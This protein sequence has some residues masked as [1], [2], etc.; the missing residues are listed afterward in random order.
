MKNGL[1]RSPWAPGTGHVNMTVGVNSTVS[2]AATDILDGVALEYAFA[3][4]ALPMGVILNA[5]GTIS[6]MPA[7]VGDY[8]FSVYAYVAG[9]PWAGLGSDAS[10]NNNKYDAKQYVVH[11]AEQPAQVPALEYTGSVRIVANIPVVEEFD[12]LAEF[13]PLPPAGWTPYLVTVVSGSLPTGL[14]LGE[15]DAEN[16]KIALTGSPKVPGVYTATLRLANGSEWGGVF[17][18]TIV[19]Y[20]DITFTVLSAGVD[21][22]FDLNYFDAPTFETMLCEPGEQVE[23]PA[24][25]RDGYMFIG[26]YT[27]N[28]TQNEITKVT[29]YIAPE[30]TETLYAGW[31]EITGNE[32]EALQILADKL[33]AG[34]LAVTGQI[35]DLT[36]QIKQLNLV[37]SGQIS[38]ILVSLSSV[39]A[40][41]KAL[42]VN[43][44]SIRSEIAALTLDLNERLD[45]IEGK[46]AGME[47]DIAELK[48]QLQELQDAL[49]SGDLKG[50]P[51]TNGTNGTDGEKGDKGDTGAIGPKG[52]KGDKGDTGDTGAKGCGSVIPTGS[53][54]G[55]LAFGLGILA[56]AAVLLAFVKRREVKNEARPSGN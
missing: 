31:L 35:A 34:D 24:P 25:I 38:S 29:S 16:G 49:A 37:T 21:V 15:F 7:I 12:V 11:V 52:D 40:S 2:I 6:G 50:D 43:D 9:S 41:L 27:D 45:A 20:C 17:Y 55:P 39:N 8:A 10:G 13:L 1:A 33:A 3:S 5:N 51:G 30:F 4:G 26:W 46:I 56:L 48:Q 36:A 53:G 47:N 44:Q 18:G 32:A 14:S 23:L 22:V 28:T 42:G 54:G 19:G